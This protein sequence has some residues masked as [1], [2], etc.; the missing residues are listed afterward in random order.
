LD[1]SLDG[2]RI[3]LAVGAVF[4]FQMGAHGQVLIF[5]ALVSECFSFDYECQ[6]GSDCG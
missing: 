6:V 2:F 5:A 1:G 3:L 4:E